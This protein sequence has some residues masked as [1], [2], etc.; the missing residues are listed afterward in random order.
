MIQQTTSTTSSVLR[1]TALVLAVSLSAACGGSAEEMLASAKDYMGKN[2]AAAATIQLKNAL[3]KNPDSAEARYLLGRILLEGGDAIA[4]EVELRKALQLK[5]PAGDVAPLLARAL[6]A[7]GQF[8]KV[9]D[10]SANASASS[11]EGLADLKTSIGTSQAMLGKLE[12]ARAAYQEAIA[13]Q[14]D[15]VPALLGLARLK[16]ADRDMEG[17][18]AIIDDAL[19]KS[20]GNAD[21]WQFKADLLRVSGDMAEALAAYRKALELNP[22]ALNAHAASV[23]I[24]LRQQKPDMA[25]SQLEAMQKA[26]AKHPLTL[27]MQGLVAYGRKDLPAVRSAMEALLKQQPNNPQGLQL[28]G[29]VAYESRSDIQ[30][31][32]YLSKALQSAPGLDHGRRV[33]VLSYLRSGQPAKA[34]TTLKP[35]LHGSETTPVWL[36]LAGEVEMQNGNA[37]AAE[38]FFARAAKADP[39]NK[40]TQTALA[41]ARMQTGQV[42]QAFAD[43]E[44]IAA[45]DSGISADLALIASSIRQKQFDKALKAIANLE[46][47][48]PNDPVTH[49]LRGGALLGKGD[50]D[51]AR[52]SFEKALSLNP[53]Y[54]PAASS[55]AKIDL[56][57]KQPD[58]A[59]QRFENVLKQDSKNV[60]AMLAL[61]QLR[62]GAGGSQDE[63]AG[64]IARA[65][66]AAPGDPAPRLAQI[67]L[68]ITAK[69]NSKALTAVQEAMAALPD[70]PEILDV[71]GRVFQFTGDTNQAL[72]TYGKLASLLPTAA[73]P[74]LRMA[75]I[76][77][78]AKNK[79]GARNSLVK[80][81]TLQPDSLPM[82]RAM[83]MLDVS[84]QRFDAALDKA[85][86]I[87]K[88][89]PREIAGHVLEGDIHVV[90]KAWKEAATAYRA[91]L[92]LKPATD[93]AERL[94]ATL[95]AGG[96]A[97]SAN[98]FA[99]DW[100]KKHPGD[101]AFRLF[102]AESASKR[103]DYP[104]AAAQYRT[105]L[106]GKQNNPALLN[107]LAWTLGRMG[108]PMAITHAEQA[109]K[110]A[111]SQPP[112]MDTLGSLLVE[113]GKD[114]ARGLELLNQAVALAPQAPEI[115]LNLA[116]ALLKT[117]KK[118][119]AKQQLDALM[120]LDD[121]HPLYAE[122]L[123]LS[124]G[125]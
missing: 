93:P 36:A 58:Q 15:Y 60:Q 102:L 43:L 35:V 39:K 109:N 49:N 87:Q 9:L 52:K 51:G 92:K 123:A 2:D 82:Q 19:A 50:L 20:P 90:K 17:A 116:K 69:D 100:L 105:L 113:Q 119:E 80:G 12:P 25:S 62:A 79:E 76:Q 4:A 47:K 70:R 89:M 54:L 38:D 94:H 117:G 77:V 40:Q 101:D 53:A 7:Q 22:K 110:L 115:R 121:K 16:I 56:A 81:L 112:I 78:A 32:E 104:A 88:A 118:A 37:E 28:A 26:A 42:D 1:T 114:V 86:G 31:Q 21:A 14:I 8:K 95:M 107:N 24:H 61:A 45:N 91:A 96:D 85:R 71:A 48:Q 98:A 41:M 6:L 122:V 66:A 65:I 64:L 103:K 13:A 108:D 75:E 84:D 124:K 5:H 33:L 29:I 83:I 18:R 30:A 44:Q 59:R 57:A 111:P 68:Y 106:A 63:V 125:L 10:E 97:T 46:R 55:L 23:M 11:K 74:Y 67:S 120:K 27:Y 72:A 34:L 73:H 99:N 3:A